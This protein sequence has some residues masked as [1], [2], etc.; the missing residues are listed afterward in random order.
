MKRYVLEFR[1]KDNLKGVG[2]GLSLKVLE[3]TMELFSSILYLVGFE[4]IVAGV[5]EVSD[6]E[7][8]DESV[9]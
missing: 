9:R 1:V 4:V 5:A 7:V 3:K 2:E 6:E 8:V